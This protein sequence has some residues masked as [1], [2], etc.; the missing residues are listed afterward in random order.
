M[1]SEEKKVMEYN[2]QWG[3]ENKISLWLRSPSYLVDESKGGESNEQS[4]KL[5]MKL[6]GEIHRS[7][8]RPNDN[9]VGGRYRWFM[10]PN[11]VP[12]ERYRSS[13]DWEQICGRPFN[14]R[15]PV[16]SSQ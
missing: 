5:K 12:L 8:G 14:R 15:C 6:F 16:V 3:R 9:S 13:A 4:Y 10:S 7:R 11:V 1:T 2:R